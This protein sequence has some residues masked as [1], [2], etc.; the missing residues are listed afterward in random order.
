[1]L[2]VVVVVVLVVVLPVTWYGRHPPFLRTVHP[3]GLE[4]NRADAAA[5]SDSA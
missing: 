3:E 4:P 1:M 2:V 5:H